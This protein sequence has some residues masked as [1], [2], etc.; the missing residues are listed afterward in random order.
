MLVLDVTTTAPL[1]DMTSPSKMWLLLPLKQ[2]NLLKQKQLLY[3]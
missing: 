1:R 2:Q 3:L